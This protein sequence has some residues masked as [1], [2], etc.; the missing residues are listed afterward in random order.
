MTV[1]V[2]VP[3]MLLPHQLPVIVVV[4]AATAVT[5]AVAPVPALATSSSTPSMVATPESPAVH[6]ELWPLRFGARV[7]LAWNADFDR[8]ML[9]QTAELHGLMLPSTHMDLRHDGGGPY[10]YA[11]D[12]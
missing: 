12:G 5:V 4:P 1:I 9:E 10:A 6:A 3:V 2:A 7:A 8:R 11:R